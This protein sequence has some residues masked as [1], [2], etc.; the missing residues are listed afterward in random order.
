MRPT[1]GRSAA[2]LY[3]IGAVPWFKP[4][5]LTPRRQGAKPQGAYGV[6]ASF[7]GK[8]WFRIGHFSLPVYDDRRRDER[9]TGG[10]LRHAQAAFS[11]AA[12]SPAASSPTASSLAELVEASEDAAPLTHR[13]HPSGARLKRSSRFETCLSPPLAKQPGQQA[14]QRTS[15][16]HAQP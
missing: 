6:V 1:G 10:C 16:A 5:D 12:S 3:R 13:T 9:E 7:N 11:P 2:P 14:G 4:S 8:A 15:A